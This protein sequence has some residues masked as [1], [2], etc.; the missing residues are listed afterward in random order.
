MSTTHF[1]PISNAM[2]NG[3]MAPLQEETSK[4]LL[5]PELEAE[6]KANYQNCNVHAYIA[7]LV[8]NEEKVRNGKIHE[9]LSVL[10]QRRDDLKSIHAFLEVASGKLS[11]NSKTVNFADHSAKVEKIRPLLGEL[12]GKLLDKNELSRR[13]V[14]TVVEVLTRRQ[15]GEIYPEIEKLQDEVSDISEKLNLILGILKE[16]SKR[17]D[18]HIANIIR[19]QIPR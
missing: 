13:E 3:T 1:D 7:E 8:L 10:E 5:S 14:E 18:D 17:Y 11:E 15:D 12:T 4:K 2:W 19:G 6:A 16:V 9:K